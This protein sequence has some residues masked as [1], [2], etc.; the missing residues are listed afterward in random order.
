ME[1]N[2]EK[3]IEKCIETL[4]LGGKSKLNY[5]VIEK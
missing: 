4:K 3:Q 2:K 5:S 1:I